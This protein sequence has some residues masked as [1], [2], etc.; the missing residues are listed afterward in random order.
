MN[1]KKRLKRFL[2]N[3]K[4]EE[5]YHC[6]IVDHRVIG[7]FSSFSFNKAHSKV[8]NI[9]STPVE[10]IPMPT[11]ECIE[12]NRYLSDIQDQFSKVFAIKPEDLLYD[13]DK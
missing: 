4:V 11:S 1:R 7:K 12:V 13:R 5:I 10:Y 6:V 8:F 9:A 2:V 3:H